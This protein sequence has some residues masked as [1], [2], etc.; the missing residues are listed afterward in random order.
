MCS[1]QSCSLM[2]LKYVKSLKYVME[3]MKII[4]WGWGGIETEGGQAVVLDIMRVDQ[5]RLHYV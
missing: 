2:I 1:L 3:L 4:H 5:G